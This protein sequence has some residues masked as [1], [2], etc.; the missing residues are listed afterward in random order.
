[1][2]K[3][4]A[5]VITVR[6]KVAKVMFLHL[7]VCPRGGGVFLSACWDTT[8]LREQTTPP[9][10]AEPPSRRL[11]L[12]TVRILLECILDVAY[13]QNWIQYSKDLQSPYLTFLVLHGSLFICLVIYSIYI[14]FLYRLHN[15][16]RH[17]QYSLVQIFQCFHS[18]LRFSPLPPW[19]TLCLQSS[20]PRRSSHINVRS[21]FTRSRSISNDFLMTSSYNKPWISQKPKLNF[22]QAAW[23]KSKKT[24]SQCFP[25]WVDVSVPSRTELVRLATQFTQYC[26]T[27]YEWLTFF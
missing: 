1:M 9:R 2:N 14:A 13:V 16:T 21:R 22:A 19:S 7:S 15:V 17:L 26:A 10:V 27:C 25:F 11:L 3:S 24:F 12:R 18:Y 5:S 23:T 8:P 20:F 4:T 6:N